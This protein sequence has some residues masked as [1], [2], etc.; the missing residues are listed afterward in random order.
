[1]PPSCR[2]VSG[3]ALLHEEPGGGGPEV[4]RERPAGVCALVC[5]L[6]VPDD[7]GGPALILQ[8]P[9]R[10]HYAHTSPGGVVA[11]DLDTVQLTC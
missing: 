1:M 9:L 2:G 11:D 5:P 3:L 7:Q 6:A 4:A 10:P 8:L